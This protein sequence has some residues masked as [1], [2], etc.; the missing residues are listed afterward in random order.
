MVFSEKVL[1]KDLE[2]P[3]LKRLFVIVFS[4]TETQEESYTSI[5]SKLFVKVF[6]ET[7]TKEELTRMIPR[8]EQTD[9][10]FPET[11]LYDEL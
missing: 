10:M 9:I 3:M 5:P 6:P 1:L 8:I 7:V 4:E 11:V 2:L